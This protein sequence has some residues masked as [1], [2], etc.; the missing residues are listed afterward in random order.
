MRPE[1][2]KRRISMT[3]FRL[4]AAAAVSLVALAAPAAADELGKHRSHIRHSDKLLH[5][6]LLDAELPV[7]DAT[8]WGYGTGYKT[9]RSGYGGLYGDGRYPGNVYNDPASYRSPPL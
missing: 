1:N 3:K 6:K 5:D 8:R 4:I 9:S 7:L 2:G